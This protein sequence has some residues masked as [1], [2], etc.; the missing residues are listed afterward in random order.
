MQLLNFVCTKDEAKKYN[1]HE[2]FHQG[3]TLVLGAAASPLRRLYILFGT[4]LVL[5]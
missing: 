3:E 4:L 5:F 1:H 2:H